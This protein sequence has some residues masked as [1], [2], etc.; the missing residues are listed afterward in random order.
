[1]HRG[2][3]STASAVTSIISHRYVHWGAD[4]A[5]TLPTQPQFCRFFPDIVGAWLHN[6][7]DNKPPT[8]YTISSTIAAVSIALRALG[9]DER[10]ALAHIQHVEKP[11]CCSYVLVTPGN[12]DEPGATSAGSA[13]QEIHWSAEFP[14]EM[15][16]LLGATS[17]SRH[18]DSAHVS[19]TAVNEPHLRACFLCGCHSIAVATHERKNSR[20]DWTLMHV[21]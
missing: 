15:G 19:T 14:S 21:F 6:A 9:Y 11:R 7:P 4:L 10:L 17:S 12:S 8:T 1:M 20:S 13:H 2:C 3:S 16:I 18:T 5:S